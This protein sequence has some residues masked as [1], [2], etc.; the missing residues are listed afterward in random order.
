M[1]LAERHGV[2]ATEGGGG[3]ENDEERPKLIHRR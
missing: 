3:E 1:K 2:V